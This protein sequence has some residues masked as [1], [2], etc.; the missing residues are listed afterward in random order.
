[1]RDQPDGIKLLDLARTA[2][3]DELL[4]ALPDDRRY[5]A[6]LIANAMAIAARELE[7]GD[8]PLRADRAALEK[9]IGDGGGEATLERYQSESMEE[10]LQRLTMLCSAVIQ[11]RDGDPL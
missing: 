8:A 7:A 3:L 11:A 9:L 10:A 6:R 2:V 1:M 4:P 5:T